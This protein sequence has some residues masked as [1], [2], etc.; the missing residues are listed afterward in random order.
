VLQS[1][2]ELQRVLRPGGVAFV[3]SPAY[4]WLLS[5][6]DHVYE[7]KYRYSA[8]ELRNVMTAAGFHVLETTYAN[9]LLFPLAVIQ[10]V[11]RILT[12]YKGQK[13]DAQ[14]WPPALEWLNGPFRRCL[15][16]EAAWLRSGRR[17]AFG[18]SVI[19]VAQKP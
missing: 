19:C 14:P 2:R 5:S 10:R 6:H 17:L 3:R 7:T 13:T 12:G 11:L 4:R 18:L 1:F 16:A 9:T 15:E 8:E